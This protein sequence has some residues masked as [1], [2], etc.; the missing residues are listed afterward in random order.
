[1]SFYCEHGN[2]TW[3]QGCGECISEERQELEESV[4]LLEDLLQKAL[5]H[6]R[7]DTEEQ[8]ILISEINKAIKE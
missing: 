4:E 2:N 6:I 3:E 1:M 5:P 8:K 7:C